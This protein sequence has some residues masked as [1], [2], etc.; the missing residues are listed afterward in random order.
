MREREECTAARNKLFWVSF[1]FSLQHWWCFCAIKIGIRICGK[2]SFS[3]LCEN[4]IC[5]L[6]ILRSL[7]NV[8]C[9][10]YEIELFIKKKNEEKAANF[11]N[12]SSLHK[13]QSLIYFWHEKIVLVPLSSPGH[14]ARP[15]VFLSLSPLS[16]DN[17]AKWNENPYL[18]SNLILSIVLVFERKKVHYES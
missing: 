2:R 9:F 12:K 17:V 5:G 15:I 13:N 4:W 14:K 16:H 11:L 7:Q 10:Q 3:E 6:K 8:L 1:A 18:V